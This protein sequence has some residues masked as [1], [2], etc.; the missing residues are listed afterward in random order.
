M[1]VFLVSGGMVN[2]VDKEVIG[3]M[4]KGISSTKFFDLI[5]FTTSEKCEVIKED[6]WWIA[7]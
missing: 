5:S 6:E 2:D 4:K 7:T 3:L 1:A